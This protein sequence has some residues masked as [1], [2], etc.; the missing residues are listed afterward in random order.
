MSLSRPACMVLVLGCTFSLPTFRRTH[1]GGPAICS[2]LSAIDIQHS[3]IISFRTFGL[4]RNNVTM[5]EEKDLYTQ[6][7]AQDGEPKQVIVCGIPGATGIHETQFAIV[8]AEYPIEARYNFDAHV[9]Q[10]ATV[11]ISNNAGL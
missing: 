7:L 3:R 4:I 5:P 2:A 10:V 9:I 8:P 1:S 6:V 11:S